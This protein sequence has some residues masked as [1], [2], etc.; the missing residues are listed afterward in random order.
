MS[1]LYFL[2]LVHRTLWYV[3]CNH[4]SQRTDWWQTG[5]WPNRGDSS[6]LF[7]PSVSS[8]CS[9]SGSLS[10]PSQ[11]CTSHVYTYY[12]I[13]PHITVIWIEVLHLANMEMWAV[14]KL[15]IFWEPHALLKFPR[16][17]E[18]L[19]RCWA[20]SIHFRKRWR[21]KVFKSPLLLSI[22]CFS[23][24]YSWQDIECHLISAIVGLA[25][26]AAPMA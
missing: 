5:Q 19:V 18:L 1:H 12:N 2:G 8:I 17:S 11:I 14:G 16:I 3:Q 25:T 4:W 23:M 9:F 7:T 15:A 6:W 10:F 26:V 20:S 22:S 13:K 24:F 21:D